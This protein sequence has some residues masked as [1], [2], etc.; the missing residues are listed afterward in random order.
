MRHPDLPSTRQRLQAA[1]VSGE[2]QRL[3]FGDLRG[4][5]LEQAVA[6]LH[7]ITED[8]QVLG[9]V[10][11]S[12]LPQAERSQAYQPP[13]DMLRAAGADERTAQVKAEWVRGEYAAGRLF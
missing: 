2:V 5:P 1:E 11:G 6:R 4:L 9:H 7:A 8:P 12:F 10:L 3:S 13:V